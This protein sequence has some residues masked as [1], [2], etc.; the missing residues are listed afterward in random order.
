[1]LIPLCFLLQTFFMIQ[2]ANELFH[3]FM[4]KPMYTTGIGIILQQNYSVLLFQN[5]Y[6]G[7]WGFSHTLIE[8]SPTLKPERYIFQ[9]IHNLESDTGYIMVNDF[10]LIS[11][12]PCKI[13][14]HYYWYATLLTLNPPK[15][16]NTRDYQNIQFFSRFDMESKLYYPSYETELWIR[17]GMPYA[18]LNNIYYR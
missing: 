9:A 18:C 2:L 11:S 5:L 7:A 17:K 13:G 10:I 12:N 3:S 8:D 15:L 6:D 16:K 14:N 4:K 1:M